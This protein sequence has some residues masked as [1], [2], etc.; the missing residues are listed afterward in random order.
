MKLEI[1]EIMFGEL[2]PADKRRFLE[3]HKSETAGP[4]I[5]GG[6]VSYECA[7]K[8]LSVGKRTILNLVRE[9]KLQRAIMPGRLRGRGVYSDSLEALLIKMQT[10]GCIS[11]NCKCDCNNATSLG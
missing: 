4:T 3:E 1:V 9:G 5:E 7:A 8:L 6:V 10:R 11:S 2:S